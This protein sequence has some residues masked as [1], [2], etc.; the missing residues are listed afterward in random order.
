MSTRWLVPFAVLAVLFLP[1]PFVISFFV[2]SVLLVVRPRGEP[3]LAGFSAVRTVRS[4][5]LRSPPL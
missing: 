3:A 4:V 1:L 5:L 2:F